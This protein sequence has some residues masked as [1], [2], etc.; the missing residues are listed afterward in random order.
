MKTFG[1]TGGVG[2]GKSTVA[3]L[4]AQRGVAVVDTDQLARDMVRPGEPALAEIRMAFGPD[5]FG[6][7][8]ALNREALAAVVFQSDKARRELEAILHPRIQ[9][10]WQSQLAAWRNEGR[11]QTAVVIPLLF[12]TGVA[13]AFDVVVCLA[14][15]ATTQQERLAARG[16]TPEQIQQRNSA[17]MPVTE[18]MAR[19]QRIIWSEGDLVTLARQC[20]R[21][22][23]AAA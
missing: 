11:A 4:L 20:D 12:E 15:S 1:I 22:F 19:A 23:S 3:G 8:G 6:A 21:V 13:S 17:Q 5:V 14:C 10:L 2:M 9:K 18:K 7:S 16:W